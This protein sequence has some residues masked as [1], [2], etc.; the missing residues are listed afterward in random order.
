MVTPDEVYVM[1]VTMVLRSSLESFFFRYV[2][3]K[4][5]MKVLKPR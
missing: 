5:L 3:A 4:P 2:D 1:L